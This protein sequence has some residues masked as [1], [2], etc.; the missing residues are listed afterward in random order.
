[1]FLADLSAH[2]KIAAP[3]ASILLLAAGPQ[4]FA[5]ALQRRQSAT[6]RQT[7]ITSAAGCQI[8]LLRRRRRRLH[9]GT[10]RRKAQTSQPQDAV[11][12]IV[13]SC[14]CCGDSPAAGSVGAAGQAVIEQDA[15]RPH[16]AAVMR[17]T[18]SPTLWA[19][20]CCVRCTSLPIYRRQ[21]ACV[22]RVRCLSRQTSRI[23]YRLRACN[24]L[25]STLWRL[26]RRIS[27]RLCRFTIE[28][29]C[30][31]VNEL[32]QCLR[33]LSSFGGQLHCGNYWHLGRYAMLQPPVLRA[34][35]AWCIQQQHRTGRC[36]ECC[37]SCIQHRHMQLEKDDNMDVGGC[38]EF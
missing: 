34:P 29:R 24:N 22:P 13:T 18:G 15:Q 5:G 4:A 37:C 32:S 11:G 9:T 26:Q 38:V 20:V 35:K 30:F 10:I 17:M 21:H 2:F 31:A 36:K 23:E 6:R 25:F 33:H 12:T 8:V 7:P 14:N 16:A 3:G 1:M 28:S 27:Q 19:I